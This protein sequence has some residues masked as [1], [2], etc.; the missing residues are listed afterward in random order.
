MSKRKLTRRQAW[1]IAKI[2]EEKTRR[3][4]KKQQQLDENINA[5]SL[6]PEQNGL[7]IAHY[8][9]SVAVESET[10]PVTTKRCHVRANIENLVTGDRVV[11]QDSDSLGVV[12]ARHERKSILAR[13]DNYHNLKPVAANIDNIIVVFSPL[14]VPHQELLDRYLVAAEAARIQPVLLLNKTDLLDKSNLQEINALIELYRSI[15][16]PVLQCSALDGF[17]IADLKNFLSTRTCVFVGQSGVGKSSLVNY[18]LPDTDT[19][20]APISEKS[21]LGQHTTTTA[22]LYHFPE[23]G[24][25]IDSPGI[26]EFALWH[27]NPDELIEQFIEFRPFIGHCKFNDCR[28]LQEPGCAILA[29]VADSR[30]NPRRLDSYRKILQALQDW[31]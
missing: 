28:H 31:K 12:V 22:V 24:D 4:T 8:G 6:G 21:S 25:L 7:V 13:P 27:I 26:R 9:N 18:L 2:Q 5:S 15:G 14:P 3:A 1:R 16:Y 10:H 17:G 19:A 30:I 23:G 20:V 11:W 29:A